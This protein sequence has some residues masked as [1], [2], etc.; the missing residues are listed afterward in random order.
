VGG[1][2]WVCVCVG[3]CVCVW[4]GRVRVCFCVQLYLFVHAF[5]HSYTCVVYALVSIL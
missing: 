3:G 2:V 1:Y 5:I 4:G